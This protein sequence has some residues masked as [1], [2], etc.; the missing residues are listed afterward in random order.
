[1]ATAF[2]TDLLMDRRHT[3]IVTVIKVWAYSFGVTIIIALVY[4]LLNKIT[5]RR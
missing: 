3:D 1:M 2:S 5:V 4:F